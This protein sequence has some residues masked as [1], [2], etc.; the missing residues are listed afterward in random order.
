MKLTKKQKIVL[1]G[2]LLAIGT[3][4][5]YKKFKS[6]GTGKTLLEQNIS[7]LQEAYNKGVRVKYLRP[8]GTPSATKPKERFDK[9][10]SDLNTTVFARIKDLAT[11][12]TSGGN[13]I[14]F[15]G[16]NGLGNYALS[17]PSDLLY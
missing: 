5:A 3:L 10:A 15:A 4:V 11:W 13:K 8:D 2:S 12:I 16:L 9:E 6:G 1:G 14:S 7:I 17:Q